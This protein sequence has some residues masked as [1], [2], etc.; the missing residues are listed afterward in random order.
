MS[1]LS[2]VLDKITVAPHSDVDSCRLVVRVTTNSYFDK[3]GLYSKK[4]IKFLKR[5][6]FGFNIL[7]EDAKG[8]GADN[9]ISRIINLNK[10]DDG[11]Y[12][13]ITINQSRDWETGYV[14]DYDYEL[15][16][17]KEEEKK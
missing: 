4:S 2:D 13:V 1:D 8:I 12:E 11:I 15:V 5:K 9:V 16:E 10:V 17:Y 6:S 3:K 7:D 14:D